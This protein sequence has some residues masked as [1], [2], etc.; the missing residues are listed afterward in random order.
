MKELMSRINIFEL[1]KL[2]IP[3]TRTV[4]SRTINPK[5]YVPPAVTNTEE[6]RRWWIPI[7]IV[8]ML[9]GLTALVYF[10]GLYQR[11]TS[12]EP[13]VLVSSDDSSEGDRL[14]FGD[15]DSSGTDT[16]QEEDQP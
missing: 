2:D 16:A 6:R 9:A 14:V 12:R 4:T 1:P 8:A 11:F 13:V 5:P 15:R 7:A 3:V 10:T